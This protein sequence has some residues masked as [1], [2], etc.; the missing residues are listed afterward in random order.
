MV[1]VN[2][3]RAFLRNL[4]AQLSCDNMNR[5]HACHCSQGYIL[6]SDNTTCIGKQLVSISLMIMN[7][8]LYSTVVLMLSMLI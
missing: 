3:M 5:S 1:D 4:F 6:N 7:V 2:V 8:S